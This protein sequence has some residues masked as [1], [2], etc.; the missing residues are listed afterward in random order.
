MPSPHVSVILPVYNRRGQLQQ[1]LDSV[2]A[3]SFQD[4]EIIIVDDGSTAAERIGPDVSADPRVRVL[5]HEKNRG[6][7]AARNT[8]VAQARGEWLSFIDSDDLWFP[9]KLERQLEAAKAAL[10]VEDAPIAVVSG[11]VLDRQ[12]RNEVQYLI[13]REFGDPLAPYRG[14]WFCPGTT[15]MISAEQF[16]RVGP[17]DE[18]LERLEDL[19]W[20]IRFSALGGKV[21]VAKAVLSRITVSRK[22]PI[23]MMKRTAEQLLQKLTRAGLLHG[24]RYRV[25]FA[26]FQLEIAAS[27][28]F[29][30]KYLAFLYH[31]AL[32]FLYA[33]RLRLYLAQ[34]WD[35]GAEEGPHVA[36][37]PGERIV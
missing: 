16:R 17:F 10:A 1:A 13:P 4:L 30:G 18:A 35:R 24:V 7:S 28:Y 19:D 5:H 11:F 21:V 33:P 12:W 26:Y 34:F 36:R 6:A 8:G 25:L 37:K 29:E 15:L 23:A 9:E 32:S 14:V 22:P 20:L 27:A 3:Q 31:V 2:L